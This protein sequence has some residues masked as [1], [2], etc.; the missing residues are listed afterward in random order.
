MNGLTRVK[1]GLALAGVLMVSVAY[2][3]GPELAGPADGPGPVVIAQGPDDGPGPV[4]LAQAPGGMGP[5]G[6]PGM[7]GHRPPMER[8]FAGPGFEGRW[9]NNPRVIE[10]L[11]LTDDQRKQFDKILLDHRENL[12]DLRAS[13]E[14]AEL[15]LQPLMQDDNPNEGAILS[16]IDKVAQARAELEKANARYLLALR[17]KLTPDQW[18]QVQEFRR[19]HGPMMR[20]RFRDGMRMHRQMG[21]GPDGK[22]PGDGQ[23]PS[24]APGPQGM[25]DDGGAQGPPAPGAPG[26]IQ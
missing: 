25:T 4:L 11:K 26:E 2:A 6:G 1:M 23:A 12:I 19:D 22:G 3:Q 5:M 13:L 21:P 16:Q 14:K 17:S 8:A 24:S 7:A 20:E 18:K 10:K 15:G 9:W